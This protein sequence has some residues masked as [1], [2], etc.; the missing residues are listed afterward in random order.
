MKFISKY[1]VLF[2]II[3]TYS[4]VFL[5]CDPADEDEEEETQDDHV[6]E[7][8]MDGPVVA[9]DAVMDMQTAV[10]S[11]SA[12]PAYR[13]QAQLHTRYDVGLMQDTMGTYYGSVPYKPIADEGDYIIYADKEA[14]VLVYNIDESE[15]VTAE[16]VYDH[17]DHCDLVAYKAI[18][19]L[20]SE[21]SY[22]VSFENVSESTIGILIP[23][24]EDSDEEHDH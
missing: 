20:H 11:L 1:F 3:L 15:N 14:V 16:E 7:H 22:V 23:M 10:D 18:Y 9:I 19:H 13:I 8:L 2:I 4:V 12:N 5:G 21:D 6:C 24:A 17:S